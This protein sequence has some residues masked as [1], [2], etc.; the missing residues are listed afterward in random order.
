M[1]AADPF[2]RERYLS[3]HDTPMQRRFRALRPWPVGCVFIQHPD[4]GEEEIRAQF[5]LMK[6]LG[7]TALKQCQVCRGTSV[8]TVMHWALEEGIIPWWFGDACFEEPT[9]EL[10]AELGLPADTPMAELREHTGYLARQWERMHAQVDATT[11]E[12]GVVKRPGQNVPAP[13]MER[14]PD[15]VPSVQPR[16]RYELDEAELPLFLDWLKRT[17]GDIGTLNEAW[18][19]HHCMIAAPAGHAQCG[20]ENVPIGWESWE[21]LAE[22][23]RTTVLDGREYRRCR[24]VFRFKADNYLR[25]L[26]DKLEVAMEMENG[27]PQKGGGEMGLFL[28][29]A[30]RGTDMEGIAA[31]MAD[32]GSFYPS[33]HLAWHFEEVDFETVRPYYMQSSLSSDWFKGGWAATWESTGG[34]QQMTG[35][36]APF[37][38]KVRDKTPGFTVD[39]GVMRQLMFSW[40]AGGYRGFGLWAWCNRTFGWEGGEYGL[41]DRNY[42]PTDRAVTAGRIGRACRHLADELWTGRKEPLVGVFQDF[43]MEAIWAAASL[44]GRDFFKNQPIRARIGVS[45]ALIDGNVPWEH[46]TGR[47]LRA[48]LAGRYRCIVLPAALALDSGLLGILKDYVEAGGRV[49]LDA[50]G[51]W[52]DEYG[53][54]LRSDEGTPFEA[55]F[56]CRLADFQYSREGNRVWSID[57][58]RVTGCTHDLQPTTATVLAEFDHSRPDRPRPAVTENRLGAGTAVVLGC[59]ASLMCTQFGDPAAEDWLRGWLT[60]GLE[61]PYRCAEAVVYR[62]ACDGADHYFLMNDRP[63]PITA[64]LETPAYAYVAAEDPVT[65]E[66]LDPQA[67]LEIPD[68]SARWVRMITA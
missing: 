17:Y 37:V 64:I 15:W 45:R 12:D 67:P 29:F 58:R 54:V 59:E 5:R 10:L 42:R 55:L 38:P 32:A 4:W 57:G 8:R 19:M 11:T 16:F 20:G 40:I 22:E 7:F 27:W 14:G 31:H 1:S 33:F 66:H 52:Y 53:R 3:L 6:E 62:L 63:E 49:V 24:D 51:G 9:P 35:Q 68:H 41:L 23:L 39:A 21:Q 25:W 34:P 50:P 13:A 18:N 48:G 61:L 44:K 36:K 47:N 26:R 28:P 60:A 2:L 43:D 46:V 56:G 65:G 30:A